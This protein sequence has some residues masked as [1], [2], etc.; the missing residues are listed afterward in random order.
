MLIL[1]TTKTLNGKL[2]WTIMMK[3]IVYDFKTAN[4]IIPQRFVYEIIDDP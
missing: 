3:S 4:R 2:T 1:G